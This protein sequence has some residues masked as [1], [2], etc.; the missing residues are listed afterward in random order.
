VKVDYTKEKSVGAHVGC[1]R[2]A[3]KKT[4]GKKFDCESGSHVHKTLLNTKAVFD[5]RKFYI[6]GVFFLVSL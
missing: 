1:Y 6:Q 3:T 4:A 5:E 2:V